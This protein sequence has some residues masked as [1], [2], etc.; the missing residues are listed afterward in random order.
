MRQQAV[1]A[2]RPTPEANPMKTRI[3]ALLEAA[4][5][6]FLVNACGGSGPPLGPTPS[7]PAVSEAA[8]RA[9]SFNVLSFVFEARV[10]DTAK[11]RVLY[12]VDGGS[13]DSTPDFNVSGASVAVPVL[14]LLPETT[15]RARL[16]AMAA[17]GNF[18]ESDPVTFRTGALPGTLS[19]L[20]VTES[21]GSQPG[22]TM[23]ALI[24]GILSG[25]GSSRADAFRRIAGP[26]IVDHSGRIVWYR[27]A[28][29]GF[30]TDWQKQPDGT[31]T[32]CVNGA[33][34]GELGYQ[35]NRYYQMDAL[36]NVIRSYF[37]IGQWPT[38]NHELRILPNGDAVLL[39]INYRTMDLTPWHGKPSVTVFG[40][41][42]E[43]I[44]PTGELL[45]AWNALDH[46]DIG[47]TDPLILDGI[48]DA[49]ELDF[50]HANS[51]DLTSDGSYLISLRHLSQ[52]LKLNQSGAIVWRLGGVDRDFT[53]VDDP[54][55][56]FSLQH[57]ARE[58]P[59][60]NI[61]LFDNGNG[62]H[63]PQS[64]AVEYRLDLNAWTA[65]MVW[66]Y[67]ADPPVFGAFMGFAQRLPNGNT[68]ITYGARALIREV[69]PGG[70]VVWEL[71]APG[72]DGIYRGFRIPSLY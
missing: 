49:D 56:G 38:D 67:I 37:A 60:G 40:N 51:I 10:S 66:Q 16:H 41:I 31:Y 34:L 5:V 54:L 47:S 46:L 35:D 21:S 6:L 65:T 22:F 4:L 30:I 43:R 68:L 48:A 33:D 2:F 63:P 36:G 58:L 52:L 1:A 72:S 7:H 42:L 53:F 29:D 39:S 55:D 14:G 23:V 9:S 28:F 13:S 59:N 20:A 70:Q 24:Q 26:M 27:E 32:A 62:H 11:V 44:S 69:T 15:Y 45:F 19:P 50:T 25:S 12:T 71:S 61:L 3:S 18:T 64:R 57:G 17:D 8:V